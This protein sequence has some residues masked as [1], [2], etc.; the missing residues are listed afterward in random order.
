MLTIVNP[1]GTPVDGPGSNMRFIGPF[2][3]G[4]YSLASLGTGAAVGTVIGRTVGTGATRAIAGLAGGSRAV[5]GVS[6]LLVHGL[7][8]MAVGMIPGKGAMMDNIRVGMQASIAATGFI[9][10]VDDFSGDMATDTLSKV[11]T[12]IDDALPLSG[13]TAANF[14]S[15]SPSLTSMRTGNQYIGKQRVSAAYGG[16]ALD[17]MRL[18]GY[19]D[20]SE[21][22]SAAAYA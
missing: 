7:A 4:G 14:N 20:D 5:A 13:Y 17:P 11:E 19:R 21:F 1:I 18:N 9:G 2:L 3:K 8:A 15:N 22:Y 6:R 12:A 10:A 16:S